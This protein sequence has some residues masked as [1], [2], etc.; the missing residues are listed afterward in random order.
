[1]PTWVL[2]L[3]VEIFAY[4]PAIKIDNESILQQVL[5]SKGDFLSEALLKGSY[6]SLCF[7]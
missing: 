2:L 1:M 5:S 3:L 7:V 4:L 6:G